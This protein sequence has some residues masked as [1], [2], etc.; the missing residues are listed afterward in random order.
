M[1]RAIYFL[2]LAMEYLETCIQREGVTKISY[3]YNYQ[4]FWN[5]ALDFITNR[6]SILRCNAM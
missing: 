4:D 5:A 1:T 2:L 6:L 3:N